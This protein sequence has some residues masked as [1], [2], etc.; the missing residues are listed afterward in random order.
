MTQLRL[1]E[2]GRTVGIIGLSTVFGLLLAMGRTPEEATDA[3]LLEMVRA[4][5]NYIPMKANIE[6]LYAAALR[7]EYASFYARRFRQ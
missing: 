1:F 5:K 3:E 4:Q 2:D 7:R 6:A